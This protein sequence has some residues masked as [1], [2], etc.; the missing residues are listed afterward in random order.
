M[1]KKI[2]LQSGFWLA[3]LIINLAFIAGDELE[4]IIFQTVC[5]GLYAVVFYANILFLF[6]SKY[7]KDKI[8]YWIYGIIIMGIILIFIETLSDIVFGSHRH[9]GETGLR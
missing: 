4:D 2:L 7:E 8:R 6:P 5:V 1:K 9:T 3:V